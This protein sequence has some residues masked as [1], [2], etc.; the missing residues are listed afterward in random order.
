MISILKYEL[1]FPNIIHLMNSLAPNRERFPCSF[2]E[3]LD[4]FF[5]LV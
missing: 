2:P 1:K 5:P 4:V 3:K